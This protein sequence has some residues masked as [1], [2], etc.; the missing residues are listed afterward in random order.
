MRM[1]L[2]VESGEALTEG[3]AMALEFEMKRWAVKNTL[4]TIADSKFSPSGVRPTM[5]VPLTAEG[6]VAAERR[7]SEAEDAKAR[8]TAALWGKAASIAI[9]AGV[10]IL[11]GGALSPAL[12]TQIVTTLAPTVNN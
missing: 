11:T 8:Q 4:N 9:A 6:I 5:S 2:K 1:A 10:T 7:A 12:A 3:D